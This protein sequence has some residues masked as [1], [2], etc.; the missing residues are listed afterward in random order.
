MINPEDTS[1]LLLSIGV[2][3]L[4]VVAFWQDMLFGAMSCFILSL[5]GISAH[6]KARSKEKKRRKE[7]ETEA[8][9]KAQS[10]EAESTNSKVTE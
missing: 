3:V 1:F 4:S 9:L 6:F 5:A 2:G 10:A 7:A 8:A